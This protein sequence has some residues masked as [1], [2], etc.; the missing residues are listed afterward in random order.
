MLDGWQLKQMPTPDLTELLKQ[1][2]K[3]GVNL[4]QIAWKAN[5][6]GLVDAGYYRQQAIELEDLKSQ[7]I[8]ILLPERMEDAPWR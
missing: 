2:T 1:L 6:L 3:V 5:S 4:N 8:D 7:I